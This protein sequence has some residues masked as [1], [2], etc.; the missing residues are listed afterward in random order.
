VAL[1][2]DDGWSGDCSVNEPVSIEPYTSSVDTW[3]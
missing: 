1:Y 2:G 3:T